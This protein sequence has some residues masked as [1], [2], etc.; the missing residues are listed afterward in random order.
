[1]NYEI[2]VNELEW[3]KMQHTSTMHLFWFESNCKTVG[4]VTEGW[5]LIYSI[6]EVSVDVIFTSFVVGTGLNLSWPSFLTNGF[7]H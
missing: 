5:Q 4:Y 6:W 3:V 1:M 7:L 2:N